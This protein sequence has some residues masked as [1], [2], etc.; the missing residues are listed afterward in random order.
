LLEKI[1][2]LVRSLGRAE[3][4]ERVAAMLIAD[5]FK[6][7]GGAIERLI[8]ARL[9]KMCPGVGGIDLVIGALGYAI[10]AD[11]R[12]HQPVAM[13]DVVETEAAF[14]TEPLLV[15]GAVAAFDRDDL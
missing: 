5:A 9:P 12:H 1:G 2:F 7:R 10:L 14:D 13:G 8:P 6:T 3:A 4:G 15:G 11:E